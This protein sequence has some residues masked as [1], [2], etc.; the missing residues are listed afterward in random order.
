VTKILFSARTSLRDAAVTCV[1]CL[2]GYTPWSEYGNVWRSWF[3]GVI[4]GII[5]VTPGLLLCFQGQ[6]Q[7]LRLHRQKIVEFGL[8]LVSLIVI[9]R[10]SFWGGYPLEYMMIPLLIWSAFRFGQR[11]STL[12]VLIISAIAV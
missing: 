4:A 1:L 10:I 2:S 9:S 11:E 5:V 8:L 6:Q 12:L 3:T 7:K